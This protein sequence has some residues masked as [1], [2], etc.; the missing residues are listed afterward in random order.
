MIVDRRLA[1]FADHE[2]RFRSPGLDVVWDLE[3]QLGLVDLGG[4]AEVVAVCDAGHA[5]AV[6]PAA[7]VERISWPDSAVRRLSPT[8]YVDVA[9]VTLAPGR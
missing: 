5:L 8:R 9:V 2:R 7:S 1:A 6:A 4:A 3:A